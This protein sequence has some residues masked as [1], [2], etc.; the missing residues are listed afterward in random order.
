MELNFSL[1]KYFLKIWKHRDLGKMKKY[2]TC[3]EFVIAKMYLNAMVSE[4]NVRKP[5]IQV[6]PSIGNKITEERIPTL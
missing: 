2:R 1:L 6:I 5:N 4:L 3:R